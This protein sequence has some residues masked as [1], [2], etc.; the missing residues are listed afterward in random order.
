MFTYVIKVAALVV[1]INSPKI[2]ITNVSPEDRAIAVSK[3]YGKTFDVVKKF[4]MDGQVCT[5]LETL[6]LKELREQYESPKEKF[7]GYTET[8]YFVDRERLSRR[9]EELMSAYDKEQ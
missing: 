5:D 7:S 4:Y 1:T 8:F 2:G 6:L 3:S 9:I